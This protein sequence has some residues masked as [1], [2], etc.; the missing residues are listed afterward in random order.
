MKAQRNVHGNR[1]PNV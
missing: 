1:E